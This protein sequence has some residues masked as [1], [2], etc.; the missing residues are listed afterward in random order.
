M[1]ECALWEREAGGSSPPP[2]TLMG[3]LL[4]TSGILLLIAGIAIKFI[5]GGKFPLLPG[6]I[7]VN[8]E[9]FTFYFPI[10]TSVVISILLTLI[11]NFFR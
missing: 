11:I 10:V 8:K 7:L 6:D 4:I 5:P 2:P 1:E 9:N 3:N